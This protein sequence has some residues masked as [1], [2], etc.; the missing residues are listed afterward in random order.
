[1]VMAMGMA[2]VMAMGMALALALALDMD[3]DLGMALVMDMGMELVMAMVMD[4]EMDMAPD[5]EMGMELV[6]E[7]AMGMA[8]VMALGMALALEMDENK[9]MIKKYRARI[10][11]TPEIDEAEFERETGFFLFDE[12]GDRVLKSSDSHA[13]FDTFAEAKEYLMDY[14]KHRIKGYIIAI[15]SS[16]DYLQQVMELNEKDI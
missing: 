6:M 7:M 11:S 1:M 14:A 4:M 13:H 10:Y 5:M 8:M 3:M 12:N 16:I 15:T 9:T 2:M